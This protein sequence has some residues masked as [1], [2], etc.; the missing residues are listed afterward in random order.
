MPSWS[1][2]RCRRA[3]A[4]S[5]LGSPRTWWVGFGGVG[6]VLD[7]RD[8]VQR[9]PGLGMQ[10]SPVGARLRSGLNRVARSRSDASHLLLNAA[11]PGCGSD[12]ERK[13]PSSRGAHVV[14]VFLGGREDGLC[15]HCVAENDNVGGR[16]LDGFEEG[17]PCVVLLLVGG[18]DIARKRKVGPDWRARG[19]RI[20]HAPH[21]RILHDG[22]RM[23]VGHERAGGQRGPVRSAVR[24]LDGATQSRVG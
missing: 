5:S 23:E 1:A 24:D 3:R 22:I 9:S 10:Y 2:E 17:G 4:G 6:G 8:G 14:D 16:F 7:Q 11:P 20:A 19:S 21:A 13:A 12:G 18:E 15:G